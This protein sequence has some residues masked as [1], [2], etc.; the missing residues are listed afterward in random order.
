MLKEE[1]KYAVAEHIA[2]RSDYDDL[3][4]R[5]MES[6]EMRM[7]MCVDLEELKNKYEG[8]HVKYNG[9]MQ[10]LYHAQNFLCMEEKQAK[11]KMSNQ[12]KDAKAIEMG[13]VSQRAIAGNSLQHRKNKMNK[14]KS[15]KNK[16]KQHRAVLLHF[17]MC[18]GI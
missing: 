17:S 6:Y 14:P 3:L 11:F 5:K 13:K 1:N 2:A 16:V 9:A 10:I 12:K 8:L 18:Q 4:K 7:S 15:W